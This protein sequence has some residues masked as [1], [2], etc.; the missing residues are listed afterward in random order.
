MNLVS[1][2]HTAVDS[3]L[4]TL[5]TAPDL[6]STHYVNFSHAIL[7]GAPVSTSFGLASPSSVPSTLLFFTVALVRFR[8]TIAEQA[9]SWLRDTLMAG[10]SLW[11]SYK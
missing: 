1:G 9:F 6:P 11:P 3:T 2:G 8:S 5:H 10:S 4:S 7:H